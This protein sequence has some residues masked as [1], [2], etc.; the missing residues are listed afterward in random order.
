MTAVSEF[1]DECKKR[2]DLSSTY[3]L[4]KHWGISEPALNN[5]YGGRRQPDEFTCFKIAETLGIDA[6]YVIAKIKAETEKDPKKAEYFKVFG[7]VLKKQAV[8]I[9]LVL[10]CV[11]SLL[12]APDTGDDNLFV[13]AA[14]SAATVLIHNFAISYNVYYVKL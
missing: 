11:L 5:Y 10:V 4:A 12:S 14:S 8:N 13:A 7:G 9:A 1:L 3:A 6:A 2:L